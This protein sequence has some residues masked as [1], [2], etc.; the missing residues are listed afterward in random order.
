MRACTH[1]QTHGHMHA[2]MHICIHT[3]LRRTY[4]YIH[5]YMHTYIHTCINSNIHSY[6]QTCIHWIGNSQSG[7]VQGTPWS[8]PVETLRLGSGSGKRL[9]LWLIKVL[10][11]LMPT[12]YKL[13]LLPRCWPAAACY[14]YRCCCA[15]P[16]GSLHEAYAARLPHEPSTQA[17][18]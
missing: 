17:S 13:R 1:A 14:E 3:Y 6:I 10:W 8:D 18:P 9:C 2:S 16:I 7:C 5:T 15:F 4:T 11:A 12:C